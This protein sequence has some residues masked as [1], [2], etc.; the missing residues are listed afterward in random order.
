MESTDVVFA[1]TLNVPGKSAQIFE[2]R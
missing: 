1:K 2:I